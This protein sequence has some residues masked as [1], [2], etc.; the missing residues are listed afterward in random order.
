MSIFTKDKVHDADS[1]VARD[2]PGGIYCA[3]RCGCK[4]TR[5]DY[6][7]ACRD[8]AEIAAALGD[9]WTVRV[10]ENGGWHCEVVKG[11]AR[12]DRDY[13][14]PYSSPR[15][16]SGYSAWLNSEVCGQIIVHGADPVEA[17]GLAMQEARTK[18]LRYEAELNEV[19][20]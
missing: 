8:G 2:L 15:K 16:I 10:W 7:R 1:W 5:E 18:L 11:I 9:G 12:V 4:C 6:E 13:E 14:I 20:A 3:P 19:S 17:L